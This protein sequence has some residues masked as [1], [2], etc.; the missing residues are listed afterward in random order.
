VLVLVWY[1]WCCAAR[2]TT[3]GFIA[4]YAASR[5]LVTGQLDPRVYDDAWFSHY[6][7]NLTNTGVLEV[8]GPN[9]PTMALLAVPFEFLGPSAAR[10]LWLVSSLACFAVASL[11]LLS[12]CDRRGQPVPAIVVLLMLL[13]PA[14]FAN[15]RTGQAYLFVFCVLSAAAICLAQGRDALGGALVGLALVLKAS[16]VPLLIL[17]VARRRVRSVIS[18]ALVSAAGSLLVTPWIGEGTWLR[19]PSYVWEFLQRPSTAVTAYQT[20]RSLARHLCIGDPVWNPMPAADCAP[21]AYAAP[22]LVIAGALLVTLAA[23]SRCRA[24]LWVA[25]GVCLSV[26]VLPVAEEHH[27]VL[28]GVP[29][30]FV[31]QRGSQSATSLDTGW[32]RLIVFGALLLVPLDYTTHVLTTGWSALGAYPRLYAAWLLW[33]FA[34]A[35]MLRS[36]GSVADRAAGTRRRLRRSRDTR[37]DVPGLA[38]DGENRYSLQVIDRRLGGVH[39][40]GP[41]PA[42]RWDPRE[43][44]LRHAG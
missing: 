3:H 13:S 14:V 1:V 32:W 7:Q 42:W 23:S 31:F 29:M 22:G 28:L 5:L 39:L 27:F 12:F 41:S 40:V 34:I 33:G 25:A 30:V 38:R 36:R 15:L 11:S 24:E 43:C 19:Y 6:V 17:L 9:P 37:R 18:A 2:R 26:L 44:R 10:T 35:T 21:V 20:T 16:G 8:F 4:Y